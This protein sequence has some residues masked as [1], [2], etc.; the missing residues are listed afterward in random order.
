MCS[1]FVRFRP[2]HFCSSKFGND[3]VRGHQGND[4][5]YGQAGDDRLYGDDGDDIIHGGLATTCY[6]AGWGPTGSSAAMAS[7][8]FTTII[9]ARRS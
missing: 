1:K 7:I 4:S 8:L 9:R 6:L 2:R 5:L 3:N